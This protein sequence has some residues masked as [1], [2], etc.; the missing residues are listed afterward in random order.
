[1]EVYRNIYNS[2]AYFYAR[3][4]TTSVTYSA[5]PGATRGSVNVC[6]VGVPDGVSPR[7]RE[8][9]VPVGTAR[10]LYLYTDRPLKS[11]W[12][13]IADATYGEFPYPVPA[14]VAPCG[15]GIPTCNFYTAR[16]DGTFVEYRY[17]EQ[18]HT[19]ANVCRDE[20]TD[21]LYRFA[22]PDD[23]VAPVVL[24]MPS[25]F[26]CTALKEGYFHFDTIDLIVRVYSKVALSSGRTSSSVDEVT[27]VNEIRTDN[28]RV[29]DIVVTFYGRMG[30][31]NVYSVGDDRIVG[32]DDYLTL[33][34]GDVSNINV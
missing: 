2:M 15:R 25:N 11:A 33:V 13:T 28:R 12:L 8:A 9:L 19:A 10:R 31:H 4:F 32:Y 21:T 16:G 26:V 3:P 24:I 5:R 27:F 34:V 30:V 23:T 20:T 29:A 1:M 17:A 18:R 6:L 7:V 14:L 22:L